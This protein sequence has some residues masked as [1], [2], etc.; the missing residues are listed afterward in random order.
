MAA[1]LNK[2]NNTQRNRKSHL[3]KA[4]TNQAKNKKKPQARQG[5][6]TSRQVTRRTTKK[7]IQKDHTKEKA[8]R[9]TKAA[10]DVLSSCVEGL[11]QTVS[12]EADRLRK[13]RDEPTISRPVLLSALEQCLAKKEVRSSLTPAA[14]KAAGKKQT[15]GHSCVSRQNRSKKHKQPATSASKKPFRKR[16]KKL[17]SEDILKRHSHCML[18]VDMWLYWSLEQRFGPAEDTATDVMEGHLV[19]KAFA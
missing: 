13:E 10:R 11:C 5:K 18:I 19:Q 6:T 8:P 12:F 1:A 2:K 3:R 7:P 4:G 15:S 16:L 9:L 14:R 17:T